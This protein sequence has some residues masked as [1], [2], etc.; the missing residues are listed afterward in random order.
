MSTRA[1]EER[2]RKG[3]WE[4]GV[5]EEDEERGTEKKHP[6]RR[7]HTTVPFAQLSSSSEL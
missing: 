4:E 6:Q 1:G 2:M 7:E 3:G 5:E